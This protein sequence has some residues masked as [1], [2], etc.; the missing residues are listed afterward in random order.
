[1]TG[2]LQPLL[3]PPA[4]AA[5][6]VTRAELLW[7]KPDHR[8]TIR[9]TLD[10][11]GDA[12]LGKMYRDAARGCRVHEVMRWL[13][14]EGASGSPELGVPRPLGWIPELSMLVYRPAPGRVLGEAM[15]DE[16][17]SAYMDMAAAWL[18]ALHRSRLPLEKR[19][20]VAAELANLH[21]W[22]SAVAEREPNA[23]R[24]ACHISR[25]LS[26]R[27]SELG[28][29]AGRP[30]HKDFHYQHV[31]VAERASV[32]D[33]D[34]VRLGDPHLDLAH[35]CAYLALLVCRFPAMRTTLDRLRDEF[36]RSYRRHAAWEI[37]ERFAAFY[38]Y[39]CLKIAKQLCTARG[40][41]PRPRGEEAHRQTAAILDEGLAALDR[42]VRG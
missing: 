42:G 11:D 27:S 6:V 22:A 20:D 4:G 31:F 24:A 21:A 18:A 37:D 39:T 30:I 2:L 32:I 7:H 40:V 15:F 25:R 17:A 13:W 41:L 9:Y 29:E 36:L 38:A 1:M 16:R 26:E 3:G 10:G 23:A 34:E 28:A 33:F 19:F 5:P 8:W 12:L 14:D 35:F